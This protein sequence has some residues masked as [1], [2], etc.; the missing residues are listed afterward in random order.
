MFFYLKNILLH[1]SLLCTCIPAPVFFTYQPTEGQSILPIVIADSEFI[2]NKALGTLCRSTG[3]RAGQGGAIGIVGCA[4]SGVVISRTNFTHNIAAASPVSALPSYGG[5]ISVSLVSNLVMRECVLNNNIAFFG[6]GNDV[7]SVSGG[8]NQNPTNTS[9]QQSLNITSTNFTSVL[10]ENNINGTSIQELYKT[11]AADL[12]H[13]CET[14]QEFVSKNIATLQQPSQHHSA[15]RALSN[16]VFDHNTDSIH[17]IGPSAE[18]GDGEAEAEAEQLILDS[19]VDSE[20]AIRDMDSR[21]LQTHLS[22]QEHAL[23]SAFSLQLSAELV[24]LKKSLTSMSPSEPGAP[25]RVSRELKSQIQKHSKLRGRINILIATGTAKLNK[26]IFNGHYKI[27]VGDILLLQQQE[28]AAAYSEGSSTVVQ[29]TSITIKDD[30]QQNLLLTVFRANAHLMST[31]GTTVTLESLLLFN[32]TLFIDK[33]VSV[34]GNCSLIDSTLN[35]TVTSTLAHGRSI[36]PALQL[37]GGSLTGIGLQPQQNFEALLDEEDE[38]PFRPLVKILKSLIAFTPVLVLD[39][40]VLE[41]GN[42]LFS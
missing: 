9:V 5:A 13:L 18:G 35:S 1:I 26:P 2:G 7:A 15:Q 16:N 23:Y 41:V 8:E 37:K 14:V 30:K 32:S 36:E 42:Y 27:V 3:P 4:S 11:Y 29:P 25:S 31:N 12:K 20:A 10:N 33:N 6:V 28:S 19:I 40:V 22:K 34:L 38:D 39:G 21:L 17:D 24:D